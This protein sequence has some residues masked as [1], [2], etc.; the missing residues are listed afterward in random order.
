[1]NII[2]LSSLAR[3]ADVGSRGQV[4]KQHASASYL[5]VVKRSHFVSSDK[6][7]LSFARFSH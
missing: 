6:V 7:N 4:S 1:M 3:F 2:S 5:K